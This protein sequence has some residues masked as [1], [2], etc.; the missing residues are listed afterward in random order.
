MEIIESFEVIELIDL[1]Q[2]LNLGK[3][4]W[5]NSHYLWRMPLPKE[6]E[7]TNWCLPW[8]QIENKDT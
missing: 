7:E 8:K 2:A 1:T 5:T 4:S 6:L 3:P